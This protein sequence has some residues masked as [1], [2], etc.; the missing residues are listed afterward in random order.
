MKECNRSLKI[1]K[2][3]IKIRK[4]K[5]DRQHNG[6]RKKDRRTNNELQKD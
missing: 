6:Q 3:V 4:W 2:G 1:Q 5:T